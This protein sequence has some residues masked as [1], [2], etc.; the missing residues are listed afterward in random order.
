[1]DQRKQYLANKINN[2]TP[3]ELVIIAYDGT[4]NFLE[5]AKR[6]IKERKFQESGELIIKAQKVIRELRRSLDLDVDEISGGLV[7]LY[8]FMDKHLSQ[9]SVKRDV[10]GVEKVRKMLVDLRESWLEISK[11]SAAPVRTDYANNN[12]NVLT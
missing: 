1:M 9:A 4:I 12:V 7:L 10:M 6:A 8:R 11:T 5:N 2:A 3:I